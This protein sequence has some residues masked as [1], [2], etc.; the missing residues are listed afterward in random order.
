MRIRLTALLAMVMVSAVFLMGADRVVNIPCGQDIDAI[1]N[2]DPSTTSTHFQLG[3]ART[4]PHRPLCLRT[5]TK[6][7]DQLEPLPSAA[8]LTTLQPRPR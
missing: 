8:L 5:V 6:S 4:Q 2:A 1:V 3:R 7:P